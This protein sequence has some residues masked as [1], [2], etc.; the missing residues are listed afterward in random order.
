MANIHPLRDK[1]GEISSYQIRVYRGRD[2]DGKQL[3]PHST[4]WRVPE[5]MKNPRTI[6]KELEKFATL[7]EAECRAGLVSSEKK[8]FAEYAKYVMSLKERDQKHTTV[9]RY[10]DLLERINSE[11]GHLKLTDVSGEHLNKLYLKLAQP[12]QNKQSGGSLSPKTIMEHHRLIH[13]IFA[14]AKKEGLVRSNPAEMATPP[15]VKKKEAEFFEI[16]EIQEIMRCLDKEPLK[17]QCITKLMIASGARR[18]EI[19]ALKWA[20]VNFKKDEIKIYGNLLY[21]RKRGIY[22]DTTKTGDSRYV[23]IDHSVMQLLAQHRRQQTLMRFKLGDA[24][25]DTGYCF[26]QANG[27]PMHP[28]SITDWLSKF[29]KKHELPH[30]NPHK[31]RH[32][33]ASILYAAGTDPIT[34][35][36]RLGHKQVSTTQNIYAHLVAKADAEAS[37]AV[38][39]VLFKDTS[40]KKKA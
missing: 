21:T 15:A 33:Q 17:W 32:T 14:Q 10:Q 26:T 13:N 38:A 23:I 28:D 27:K 2:A 12:G 11:I 4:T 20:N 36:K 35:S 31:F 24:W 39:S 30:I 8:T 3:K 37:S 40:D 7:Y 22:E 5:G 19:M 1:N 18:G 25:E 29:S 9:N 16:E 6:K 34:I